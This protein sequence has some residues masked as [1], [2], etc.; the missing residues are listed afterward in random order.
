LFEISLFLNPGKQKGEYVSYEKLLKYGLTLKMP[1]ARE[2]LSLLISIGYELRMA[3][4]TPIQT[5]NKLANF[6]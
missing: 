5:T 4:G 6:V 3:G 1:F 2:P